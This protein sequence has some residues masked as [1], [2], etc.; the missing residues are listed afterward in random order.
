MMTY[1]K[2]KDG[3]WVVFAT[4]HELPAP[5]QVRVHKKDGS[6]FMEHVPRVSKPFAVD[7]VPHAYG[8]IAPREAATQGRPPVRTYRSTCG[9]PCHRA[10]RTA[11]FTCQEDECWDWN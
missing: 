10:G 1:R 8:T 11:C 5:G 3:T 2:T 9:C 4:A 7:G 6:I